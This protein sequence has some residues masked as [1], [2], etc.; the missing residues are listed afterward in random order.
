[1]EAVQRGASFEERARQAEEMRG[2]IREREQAI[3]RLA[4]EASQ[5]REKGAE[6]ATRLEEERQ[7]SEEK[8]ALLQSAKEGMENAFKSLSAE[9]LRQ[10]NQSF[11]DLAT[12]LAERIPAGREGR[13]GE[14][15][16]RHR[17]AGRARAGVARKVDE[18]IARAG[19]GARA[20]LRRDSPA[21]HADGPG[22]EPG[23]RDETGNLVKALRQSH[24]R[25]RWGEVQLRR[26]VEMAGMMKHCD[27]VEQESAEDDDGRIFVPT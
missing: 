7:Q 6:L 20:R 24:V 17:C 25:G 5:L 22:A 8:L 23:L 26:V 15:P 9:A 27:F 11:L 4:A 21:V 16:G 18:K 12:H 14:A 3:A 1:M 19:E 10:N 2:T 13:P